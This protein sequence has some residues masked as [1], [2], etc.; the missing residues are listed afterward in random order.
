[1]NS[2]CEFKFDLPYIIFELE[3][4]ISFSLFH[5]T[6]AFNFKDFKEVDLNFMP[7]IVFLNFSIIMPW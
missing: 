5:D 4:T 7:C 6:A 2:R 3:R 1:M